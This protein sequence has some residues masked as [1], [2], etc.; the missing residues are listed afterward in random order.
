[1]GGTFD[2]QTHERLR[3]I[4]EVEIETRAGEGATPH[5]AV[6]W[7]VVDEQDRVFIRSVRAAA[8]RWYR[9]A[10]GHPACVVLVEDEAIPVEA[11]AATDPEQVEACSRA[12]RAKY[13]NDGSLGSMLR[14]DT[15]PTT[16]RLVPR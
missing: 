9:E 12:L 16:L 5:R 1:M 4:E 11:V 8:G 3:S 6:I 10:V 13:A 14:A 15:L 2:R 7:V